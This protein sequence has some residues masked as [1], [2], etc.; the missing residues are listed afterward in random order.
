[1]YPAWGK[2]KNEEAP[3]QVTMV[4]RHEG[5]VRSRVTLD[6]GISSGWRTWSRKTIKAKDAG[7][8]VVDVMAPDGTRLERVKFSVSAAASSPS[9]LAVPKVI[10]LDEVR[11][12]VK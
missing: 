11:H 2:V 4:W 12:A 5:K 9:V 6:V 3:S 1:M 10:A 8:W 7:Q